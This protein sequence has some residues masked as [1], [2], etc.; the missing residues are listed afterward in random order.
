MLGTQVIDQR[1]PPVGF[2]ENGVTWQDLGTYQVSGGTLVVSLSDL[3]GPPGSYVIADAVR[4]ER[5]EDLPP[6]SEVVVQVGGTDIADGTGSVDFGGTLVGVPVS[7]RRSRCRTWVRRIWR[8]GRSRGR[9]V[10]A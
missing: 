9:V 6:A 4:I 1:Q 7:R 10:S 2:S 5:I 8:W 3:A